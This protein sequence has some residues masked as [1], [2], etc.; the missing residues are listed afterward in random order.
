MLVQDFLFCRSRDA[1]APGAG[2]QTV[3]PSDTASVFAGEYA[4]MLVIFGAGAICFVAA[5]GV[6]DTWTFTSS[7]SYPQYVF[8]I[9]IDKVMSTGTSVAAGNIKAIK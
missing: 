2:S 1:T 3:V 5:D 6:S 9:A 8:G 7:M 4:R